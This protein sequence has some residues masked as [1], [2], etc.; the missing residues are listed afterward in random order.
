MADDLIPPDVRE[1]VLEHVESI[2]HLE[3]LLL[4]LPLSEQRLSAATVA[5]RLYVDPAQAESVLDQLRG[6]GLVACD[7]GLYWFN[8]DPGQRD[9][10]ERLAA[11]YAQH[12]ISITDLVHAKPSGARA[13]A[14]AVCAYLLLQA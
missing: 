3:A 14:A 5:S 1:F 11:L 9:I 4:L 2:A 13:F 8:A 6:R 7:A 12:L 10:I